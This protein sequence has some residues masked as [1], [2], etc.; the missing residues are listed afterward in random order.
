MMEI[1]LQIN[2]QYGPLSLFYDT[3]ISPS[4]HT[5]SPLHGNLEEYNIQH[6]PVAFF[7][8]NDRSSHQRHRRVESHCHKFNVVEVYHPKCIELVGVPFQEECRSDHSQRLPSKEG[9]TSEALFSCTR[10]T[11]LQLNKYTLNRIPTQFTGFKHLLYCTFT[12][13]EPTYDSLDIFISKFPLLLKLHL[14]IVLTY[15]NMLFMLIFTEST[16]TVIRKPCKCL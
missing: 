15:E 7:R 5:R 11:T 10:F 16:H 3:T 13:M 6:I 1:P 9:P 14:R 12:C 2:S 8:C 4:S